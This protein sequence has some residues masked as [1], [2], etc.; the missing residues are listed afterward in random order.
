[1]DEDNETTTPRLREKLVNAYPELKVSE[2]TVASARQELGWVPNRLSIVNL[3][4]R[5]INKFV[6]SGQRS[7]MI[8][9]N[10]TFDNVIFTDESSFQ[11]EYHARRTYRRIG[12]SAKS[13][14][15]WQKCMC[16]VG[17][18]NVVPLKLF[19]LNPI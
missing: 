15:I 1:M 14:N 2:R 12:F 13:Q 9:E 7:K 19:S 3:F 6:W 4:E 18:R 11:V 10:E 8:A 16:G 17:S 5:Q